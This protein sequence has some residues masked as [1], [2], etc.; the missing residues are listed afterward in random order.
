LVDR[1]KRAAARAL[2]KRVTMC[3]LAVARNSR[4]LRAGIGEEMREPCPLNGQTWWQPT[5]K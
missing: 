3:R 4:G 5:A 2:G 1:Q